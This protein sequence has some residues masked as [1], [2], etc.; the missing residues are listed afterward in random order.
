[1]NTLRIH[2]SRERLIEYLAPYVDDIP[3]A[4][5]HHISAF[6]T[7]PTVYMEVVISSSR[8]DRSVRVHMY[9]DPPFPFSVPFMVYT[10][11]GSTLCD[12][13]ERMLD[14]VLDGVSLMAEVLAND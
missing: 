14:A 1:M 10:A 6:R 7:Q 4:R 9:E 5:I 13:F 12:T 11:K 3:G 2:E 8:L